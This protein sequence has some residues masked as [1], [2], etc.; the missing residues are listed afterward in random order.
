MCGPPCLQEMHTRNIYR[1]REKTDFTILA[2]SYPPLSAHLTRASSIDFRNKKSILTLTQAF[3]SRDFNLTLSMPEDDRLIPPIPQKLNYILWLEDLFGNG[4]DHKI[5]GIDIGTGSS[6]VYPLIGARK[7]G[8][9][10][11]ATEIDEVSKEYAERNVRDNKLGH[12]IDVRLVGREDVLCGVMKDE[13]DFSFCM[14]NPP[15]FGSED[16]ASGKVPNRTE[17]RPQAKTECSGTQGERVTEGGE[18]TFVRSI[19]SDSMKLQTRIRLANNN[20]NNND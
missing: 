12:L 7:N 5:R 19:V 18:L 8:W 16:E 1:D 10:F 13:S 2:E 15:F 20:N 11:L 3:L 9:E 17:R 14:C 4:R 6:C